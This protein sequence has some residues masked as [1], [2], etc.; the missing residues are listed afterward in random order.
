MEW[1][2]GA[3]SLVGNGRETT[4]NHPYTYISLTVHIIGLPIQNSYRI[5]HPKV[6][7]VPIL[8]LPAVPLL[9]SN[10]QT[11]WAY[12]SYSR[13]QHLRNVYNV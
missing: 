12:L 3:G 13:V 7:S 11:P 5:P 4:E 1:T 10:N 6:Q 9:V 2:R 8:P